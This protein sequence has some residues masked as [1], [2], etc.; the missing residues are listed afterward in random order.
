LLD[1]VVTLCACMCAQLLQSCPVLSDPMDCSLPSS[2]VHGILQER[3]LEWVAMPSSRG[4]SQP[5]NQTRI[6][7]IAGRFFTSEPPGKPRMITL[8]SAFKG[9]SMLF[10]IV[11]TPLFIPTNSAGEFSFL[12]TLSSIY[13][14]FFASFY[15][16][17]DNNRKSDIYW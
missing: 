4:S 2:S 1:H 6:S 7:C 13:F 17:F 3:I 10:S 14:L 16:F 9:T 15:L 11:A 8:L 12:H 5:R